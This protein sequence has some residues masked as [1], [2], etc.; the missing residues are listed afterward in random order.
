MRWFLLLLLA[1][2]RLPPSEVEPE[3][4]GGVTATWSTP[5][6]DTSLQTVAAF[7]RDFLPAALEAVDGARAEVRVAQFLLTDASPVDQLLASLA[8]AAGRGVRVRVLADE[9]GEDTD[10]VIRNLALDGVEAKLDS[11]RVM[12]HNK[13]VIADDVVVVGSHNW[14]S[15][16]LGRNHEA[17]LRLA[18][19]E[20][21][22]WY[23]AWFDA[24]WD[25]PEVDPELSAWQRT[26]LVPLAG[27]DV[28]PALLDCLD[29]A[30]EVIELAM[31][32][33]LW[34]D[35]YPG[36]DVDL[37][38]TAVEDAHARGVEVRVLLDDSSWVRTNAINDDAIARLH[39]AGIDVWRSPTDV[40]MHAKVLRCDERLI[41]SDANW[42]Y[43]GL[44]VVHGTSALVTEPELVEAAEAWLAELRA[45]ARVELAP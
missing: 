8:R 39:A 26:D 18:D 20:V 30:S 3:R 40:T 12:T 4:E 5:A 45:A 7:D 22:G 31:Y 43:S 34:D 37:V 36:S 21:S 2:T 15:S 13:L 11:P 1:C 28:T 17:S 33:W 25:A 24:V 27:R 23:A 41:V 16:A 14:T 10:R 6:E 38:L 32:C 19:A 29:G 35:R 9:E 44:E 42:T